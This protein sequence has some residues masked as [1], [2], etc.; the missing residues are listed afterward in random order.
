LVF[1]IAALVIGTALR[2]SYPADIEY[3]SDE[4]WMFE[5]TQRVAAGE[6]WPAVG[7]ISSERVANPGLSV[8][9]FIGLQKL[10]G[11]ETPVGLARGVQLVNILALA[12]LFLFVWW[13]VPEGERRG[14]TWGAS[15][16]CVSPISVIFH[17]KIWAQSLLPVFGMVFLIGWWYRGRHRSA[18]FVWGLAGALL[19]QIHMAGFFLT[20]A[21]L[22]WTVLFDSNRKKISWPSWVLGSA[23][24]AVTLIPWLIQASARLGAAR[25][26]YDVS[27][28]YLFKWWNYWVSNAAGL[29]LQSPLRGAFA[30]FLEYPII[31]GRPTYLVAA[32]HLILVACALYVPWLLIGGIANKR[33]SW[34][35]LFIG[36]SSDSSLL[37]SSYLWGCGFLM[38][39]VGVIA[40]RH[41]LLVAFPLVYVWFARVLA[42]DS[43]WGTRVYG[44][45]WSAQLLVTA[46]FLYYVHVNGGVLLGTYRAA[47]PQ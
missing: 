45:A 44:I 31:G 20:A 19:G 29:V 13:A 15:L 7:M 24:G 42:S 17:R 11:A 2:L 36:K 47:F 22:A 33:G 39:V 10:S 9:L 43:R 35:T 40:D 6:A 30:S 14:W 38:M 18:A 21:V 41:Y 23:A 27:S 1:A 16:A 28:W 4:R 32:L 8:W 25:P 5:M 3:K 12:L 26:A 37:M 46:L 34:L